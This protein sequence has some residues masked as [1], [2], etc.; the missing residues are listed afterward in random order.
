MTQ[1]H[2]NFCTITRWCALSGMGRTST[3]DALRSGQ[4]VGRK[5]GK[6]VLIDAEA[7]L[8]WLRSL[9]A[10]RIGPAKEQLGKRA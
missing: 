2:P 6:R 3:Y 10:C 4:L 1:P 7:G 8:A 9:P 5:L